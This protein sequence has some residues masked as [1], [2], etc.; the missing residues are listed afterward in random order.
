MKTTIYLAG[1]MDGRTE[2]ERKG[3]RREI[4]TA[5]SPY[6]EFEDPTDREFLSKHKHFDEINKIVEGDKD[7]IDKSDFVVAHCDRPSVGTSM[8]IFYAWNQGKS[9]Y[10]YIPPGVP[11]SPWIS[12]HS[13][14]VYDSL[15]ELQKDL[16]ALSKLLD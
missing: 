14:L 12:Y 6:F 4:K 8:E 10:T 5:L 13:E 9:V 16:I 15:E 3:W 7:A 1:P 2:E 11:I